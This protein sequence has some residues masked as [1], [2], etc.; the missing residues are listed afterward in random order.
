M[1]GGILRHSIQKMWTRRVS[2]VLVLCFLAL[3]CISPTA[4]LQSRLNRWDQAPEA[5]ALT[6]PLHRLQ[7]ACL[8]VA[9]PPLPSPRVEARFS[10]SV[11]ARMVPQAAQPQVQESAARQ[12]TPL[13]I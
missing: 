6:T 1:H 7:R 10:L 3:H 9:E 4:N 8:P 5:H 2:A 11:A 12:A 13:R